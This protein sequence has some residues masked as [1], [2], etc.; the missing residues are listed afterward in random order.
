[1]L[2]ATQATKR[3]CMYWRQSY[4]KLQTC[5]SQAIRIIRCQGRTKLFPI[6]FTLSFVHLIKL[7]KINLFHLEKIEPMTLKKTSFSSSADS[8]YF[9][10]KI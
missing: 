7:L 6:K 9:V 3:S 4:L 1:M 8:Q 10:I 5:L 2:D